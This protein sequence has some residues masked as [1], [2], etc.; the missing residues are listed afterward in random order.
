MVQIMNIANIKIKENIESVLKVLI[1]VLVLFA[2]SQISI[3][4]DPVPINLGT[5]GVMSLG[6]LYD[7][8]SALL[9]TISFLLLGALGVPIFANFAF[10]LPVLV[11]PRGGYLF[12]YLLA[13]VAMTSIRPYLKVFFLGISWL[14]Y[15]FGLEK[16]L[17]FGLWP[18]LVPGLVK[19]MILALGINYIKPHVLKK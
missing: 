11:G 1:G 16:A 5:V 13:V 15:L 9:S 8:R 17:V 19:A 18:F 10:G 6:L 4:L 3:P 14:S 7:R 2:T 12:G